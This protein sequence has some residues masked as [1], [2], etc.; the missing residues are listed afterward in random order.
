MLAAIDEGMTATP[1]FVAA[2]LE[3]DLLESFALDINYN[4]GTHSR[5]VGFHTVPEERLAR[6]GA[7]ALGKLN[8]G[9]FLLP[10]YMVVASLSNFRGMMERASRL[11]AADR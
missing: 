8:Q 9:G 7:E 5:F 2:L 3:H 10:I 1:A 4:D 11:N 6:L